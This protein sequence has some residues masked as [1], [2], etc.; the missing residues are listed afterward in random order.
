MCYVGDNSEMAHVEIDVHK[1]TEL[2]LAEFPQ[3]HDDFLE[4]DGL[5]HLQMME[6]SIFTREAIR[7]GNWDTVQ[8]CLRL[9]DTF[10]CHGDAK[11][12]NAIYVS[13]LEK[14]PREGEIRARI[15]EIM[16]SELRQGWDDILAYLATLLDKDNP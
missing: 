7:E 14:L 5:E 1:C 15:R 3:L 11:I 2:V 9:A 4:W 16:T 8:K 13:Y 10:L 12:K 6:F